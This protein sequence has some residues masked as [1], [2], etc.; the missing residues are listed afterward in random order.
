[1]KA[2]LIPQPSSP[3]HSP[4]MMSGRP[5]SIFFVILW[6][7]WQPKTFPFWL[8]LHQCSTPG[9]TSSALVSR[10]K[11]HWSRR[12]QFTRIVL[13]SFKMLPTPLRLGR[14][15]SNLVECWVWLVKMALQS[16][17]TPETLLYSVLFFPWTQS[18]QYPKMLGRWHFDGI[19]IFP[20]PLLY[21]SFIYIVSSETGIPL[22]QFRTER[23][24]GPLDLHG[25]EC[26]TP[27]R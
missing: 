16:L 17:Y 8:W 1:M 23:D 18:N 12:K 26:P 22:S 5:Y 9:Q 11:L 2:M 27:G 13:L 24:F 7:Q 14:L 4:L 6:N 10:V 21:V 15:L 25:C 19:L 3:P 20:P